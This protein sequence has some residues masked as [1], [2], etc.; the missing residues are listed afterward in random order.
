MLGKVK[1][2]VTAS[3][4]KLSLTN[5]KDINI[6]TKNSAGM[7]VVNESTAVGKGNVSAENTGTINLTA[8][9]ATNEKNIGILADK[10]TGINIGNINVKHNGII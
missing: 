9:A 8:S 1:S 7:M 5:K 10:A 4:A 6:N 3:T 2:T